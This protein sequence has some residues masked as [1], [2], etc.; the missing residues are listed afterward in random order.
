MKQTIYLCDQFISFAGDR[1]VTANGCESLSTNGNQY[2]KLN[3]V[4]FQ[5]KGDDE[6]ND[7]AGVSK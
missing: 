1:L 6:R 5:K 4:A 2:R 7:F 3:R